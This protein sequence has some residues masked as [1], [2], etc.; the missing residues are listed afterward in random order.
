MRAPFVLNYWEL[1]ISLAS[2]YALAQVFNTFRPQGKHCIPDT[3]MHI[4]ICLL[5]CFGDDYVARFSADDRK[6]ALLSA[7]Q[8]KCK[9]ECQGVLCVIRAALNKLWRPICRVFIDEMPLVEFLDYNDYWKKRPPQRLLP[10][11][12]QIANDLPNSGQVLDIGCGDGT[13]LK[14]LR[15][16]KP[17]LGLMGVDVSEVAVSRLKQ[18]GIRS[19]VV[20]LADGCIPDDLKADYVVMMEVLEHIPDPEAIMRAVK[21]IGARRYYV[22]I[23]NL[24]HIE[25]RLRLMF[26]GKMPITAIIYH[27]REHLRFWTVS[28][29]KYWADQMGYRV[30]EY[31]GQNGTLFFWRIFPSLFAMQMTYRLELKDD[32]KC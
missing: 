21:A 5:V 8:K 29:F 15:N 2:Y 6:V 28:D 23:P 24:G 20:D 1:P 4:G 27:M 14:H 11:Y 32:C 13:F 26:A 9:H 17:E 30:V 3:G 25:H 19:A 31:R 16:V 22:T 12:K 7:V 10:R 18:C